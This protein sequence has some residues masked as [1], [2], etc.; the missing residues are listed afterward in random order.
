MRS[1]LLFFLWMGTTVASFH[2]KGDVLEERHLPTSRV[3]G[4]RYLCCTP[5]QH[6]GT[7]VVGPEGLLSIHR[8]ELLFHLC[9]LYWGHS[10]VAHVDTMIF[11]EVRYGSGTYILLEKWGADS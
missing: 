2:C 7:D 8:E 5:P 1:A 6:E 11:G 4:C 10:V 3:S 9:L